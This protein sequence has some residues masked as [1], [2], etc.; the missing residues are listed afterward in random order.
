MSAT[1]EE[2]RNLPASEARASQ[3]IP[4]NRPGVASLF[5]VAVTLVLSSG[6]S[7]ASLPAGSP[8]ELGI[9]PTR[10]AR[11]DEVIK[12]AIAAKE[13]PGAVL[14]VARGGRTVWRKAYGLRATTPTSERMTVDTIFDVASLT[15][16]VAT[17]TSLM[18]LVEEGKVALQDPVVKYIPEFGRRGKDKVTVQHL[19]THYSGLRP[20]LDLDDPWTGRDRALELTWR[21]RLEA[22]PGA[23]F[24]YSDIN[25][26]VLG[27]LI[28]RVSGLPVNEFA[29]RRIFEPLGMKDTGFLPPAEKRARIAPTERRNGRMLRGSVHD[30]TAERMGGVAGHAGLFST[31]DDTAVWAQMLLNGGAYGETRILSPLG[32][33]AMSSP[34]SP[35]TGFDWR[36]LGFDI[37]TRFSTVRGALFPRGSFGHTGFTGTSVWIDPGTETIV[38]LFTNRLHP[39]GAGDVVSLRSRVASVVAASLVDVPLVWDPYY[40]GY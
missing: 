14:L 19:L 6:V 7:A 25:Y 20:D 27:E 38:I 22:E 35:R 5:L 31:V 33:L 40:R 30:P 29:A 11:V 32:V 3:S 15:K 18:I 39:N 2:S 34:Q 37:D 26:I 4:S 23:E 28:Q 12:E 16:V 24:I 13:L 9:D 1:R 8:A 36:G 17:A 10:L 21:E